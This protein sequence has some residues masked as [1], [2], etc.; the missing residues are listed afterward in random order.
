MPIETKLALGV[1]AGAALL[2]ARPIAAQEFT[3]RLEKPRSVFFYPQLN[4]QAGYDS[5]GPGEGIALPGRGPRTQAAAEW[6]IK[7]RE[8]IQLGY[9]RFLR[10]ELYNLKAAV[11]VER[12]R[13][14]TALEP[15]FRLYDAWARFSTKWD[16]TWLWAGRK[17]I[18][19]GHNPQL[20]PQ[21]SFLPNQAGL[22]LGA[23]RDTGLFLQT[24]VAKSV[25][26]ELSGTLGHGDTFDYHGGWLATSR[27]GHST[28]LA[29][30]LGLFA[31]G[32]RLPRNS[33]TRTADPALRSVLRAGVDWVRKSRERA[34]LVNQVSVGFNDGPRASDDRQIVNVL[35]SCEWYPSARWSFGVSHDLRLEDPETGPAVGAFGEVLGTIS[36]AVTRDVRFRLN[37]FVEYRNASGRANEGVLVQLCFGCGL[38][39]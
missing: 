27:L 19:Y 9:T 16:R 12:D 35:N 6:L 13:S 39:K 2:C 26:L 3:R 14:R 32:G 20:D 10:P 22:D 24:P 15:R 1:V 38:I 28:F 17:P 34:K 36:Y 21:Q 5:A 33:G 29:D 18:P 25:D 37:P 31:L 11:E 30:E 7:D 23:V 4:L 8:V